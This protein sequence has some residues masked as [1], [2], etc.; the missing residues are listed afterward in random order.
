MIRWHGTHVFDKVRLADNKKLC[1]GDDQDVTLYWDGTNLV[2]TSSAVLNFNN[3]IAATVTS[4]TAAANALFGLVTA[5]VSWTSGNL[6]GVRGRVT[7]TATGAVVSATGVHAAVRLQSASGPGTGL[8]C[9]LNAEILATSTVTPNAIVY[10]QSLPQPTTGLTC[11]F[12]TVPYL[13]FSETVGGAGTGVG[14]NILFEVGHAPAATTPTIGSG[15]LFYNHA[16]QIAV[17]ETAGVRTAFYIPLS[18]VQGTYTTEYLIQS[19][20]ATDSTSTTTG[21][22]IIAGGLGVAGAVYIGTILGMNSAASD[23]I[24]KANTQSA[25]EVYDATTKI[26]AVDTRNT[27]TAVTPIGL[28]TPAV[29]IASATDNSRY[30]VYITV[31]TTTFSGTATVTVLNGM[32]LYV[33]A[34]VFAGSAATV[35]KASTVYIAGAP[36]AGGSVTMTAPYSLEIGA[37]GSL[38]GGAVTMSSTLGIAGKI[39]STSTTGISFNPTLVP[40]LNRTNYIWSYGTRA[41]AKDLSMAASAD[42]NLDPIQMNL[43]IIGTAP[44]SSTVN[45][46]YMLITHAFANMAALRLKCSDWNVVV[47]KNILDAY[48]MQGEVDYTAAVAVG[49]ESAVLG[50]VMRAYSSAMT[51]SL[52]GIILS[53]EGVGMPAGAVGLEIRTTAGAALGSGLAEGIRIAGTP[54]PIVGIAMG[55]QT[56]D[57]EGPQNAFFFPSIG[58]ADEG[59]CVASG[60]GTGAIK[61]KIGSATRYIRFW[62]T[63]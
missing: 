62:E 25:L 59:P 43:N 27:V 53:M 11:S 42:Y 18:T 46:S 8:T 51:G 21:A 20:L 19:S 22:V 10:I 63:A 55:N 6:V 39:T 16:L 47:N 2:L 34:P 36:T 13:V 49:G 61:I 44:T 7:V 14:S 54:L 9:A 29:T 35:S 15:K 41:T 12:A 5:D 17:N 38:F 26:V 28:T 40:D 45:L 3:G 23:I 56:N 32:G 50:L 31:G 4:P 24:I 58:G 1:F 48:C 30:G 33:A 57:N 37:G 52:R 60:T